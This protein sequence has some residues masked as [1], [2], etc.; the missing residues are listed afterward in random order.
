MNSKK[1]QEV[2]GM[3]LI[4]L[5]DKYIENPKQ[6]IDEM[7]TLDVSENSVAFKNNL[8]QAQAYYEEH[9]NLTLP[10]SY[11]SLGL[12]I[13]TQRQNYKKQKLTSEQIHDLN[14][15]G[16]IWDA[17]KNQVAVDALCEENGISFKQLWRKLLGGEIEE[18]LTEEEKKNIKEQMIPPNNFIP[19]DE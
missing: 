12:W 10:Q 6:M 4:E 14:A 13:G 8:K 15:I 7:M 5:E 9:G 17:D 2:T 19:S 16:M 1:L 18:N 3:S 11:G